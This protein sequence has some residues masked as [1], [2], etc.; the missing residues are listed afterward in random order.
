[1][2]ELSNIFSAQKVLN[3]NKKRA[4]Q[5]CGQNIKVKKIFWKKIL[6]KKDFGEKIFW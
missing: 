4:Q 6:V 5:I 2:L 1:M 3:Q